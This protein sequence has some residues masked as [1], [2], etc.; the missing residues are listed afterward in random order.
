MRRAGLLVGSPMRPAAAPPQDRTPFEG[1]VGLVA[2]YLEAEVPAC[3][4]TRPVYVLG[5]SFGGLLAL[6]VAA[7]CPALVDRL[8]LVNPATSFNN[9][10]WPLLGPLLPQVGGGAQAAWAVRVERTLPRTTPA[11]LT[12]H[13]PASMPPQV[14]PELYRALPLALAPLLGNPVNLLA[15][16]LDG[17]A[18]APV[19]DQAGALVETAANLLQQLP[20]LAEILPAETLAWKL[21]LLA[22]GSAAVEPL[23]GRVPQR[24]LLMVGDQVRRGGGGGQQVP[25]WGDVHG[26]GGGQHHSTSA[27]RLPIRPSLPS[28]LP[29]S[30]QDLLIP[31]AEE[32]PRLQRALPRATLRVERGRSHAL[33]QEGGVD[34][35]GVLEEEGFYV[36]TRRMSAPIKCACVA[37]LEAVARPRR[38]QG[39]QAPCGRP[40]L[41][42]ATHCARPAA[43]SARRRLALAPRHPWSFPARRSL[44]SEGGR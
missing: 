35:V 12:A 11:C 3:T 2:D 17:T 36:A 14:P 20:V 15:A 4:P 13:L 18:G 24:C 30:T 8:V 28:P 32:G 19:A 43:G 27:G 38:G 37:C 34:L 39:G 25:G 31:S 42:A 5:E 10:L 1:L 7:R 29:P 22:Q 26:W 44:R 6:A 40:A 41:L 33:L 23:L 21:Q 9:S 16:G